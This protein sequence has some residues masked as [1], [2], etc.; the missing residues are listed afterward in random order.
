[1]SG[2]P[3]G[4]AAAVAPPAA[5]LRLLRDGELDVVGRL[6]AASN[7]TLYCTVRLDGATASCVYKP[8]AGERPLWDFPDGSLAHREVAAYAVSEAAGW[9]FVPPTV[10]RDGP[11]GPGMCQ[12]W[13]DVDESV[14]VLALLRGSDLRLRAVALFDAVINNADR[15]GGHVLPAATGRLYLVDHGVCFAI[16]DKLRTLLWNWAGQPI[17]EPEIG[18]L[19][20]LRGEL[21]GSLGASLGALLAP[22][23]VGTTID[24]LDRLVAVGAFPEPSADWPAVP[25]PPF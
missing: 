13:I 16:E 2:R 12:L 10:M 15:K 3:D 8:I 23:E 22:A 18:I 6:V 17:S 24:R 4:S 1:M 19:R 21:D 20:Q 9:G 5:T 14:D 7:A 11:F 25:W